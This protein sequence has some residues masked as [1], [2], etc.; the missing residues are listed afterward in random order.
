ME[1]VDGSNLSRSAKTFQTLTALSPSIYSVVESKCRLLHGQPWPRGELRCSPR[2]GLHPQRDSRHWRCGQSFFMRAVCWGRRKHLISPKAYMD[3]A[4]CPLPRGPDTK[5]PAA[6]SVGFICWLA[7]FHAA[8]R[9][10]DP[11]I[12]PSCSC[13]SCMLCTASEDCPA[14]FR[15][16]SPRERRDRGRGS[17]QEHLRGNY[18]I[19]GN[20]SCHVETP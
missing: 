5:T 12:T 1:E 11:D 15:R 3:G 13:P 4:N 19:G 17:R 8:H 9:R 18:R 20:R 16:P 14:R 10:I 7:R 6:D 2:L